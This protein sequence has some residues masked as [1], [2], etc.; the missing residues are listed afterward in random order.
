MSQHAR[1]LCLQQLESFL[2]DL[3]L[4]LADL[5][6]VGLGQLSILLTRLTHFA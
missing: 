5:L 6:E 2:F 4:V 1:L 3:N